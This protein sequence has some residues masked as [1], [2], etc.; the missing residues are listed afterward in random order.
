M[1]RPFSSDGAENKMSSSL[2]GALQQKE[3][4]QLCALM[5]MMSTWKREPVRGWSCWQ[6]LNVQLLHF[7]LHHPLC[8]RPTLRS[9]DMELLLLHWKWDGKW[10]RCGFTW[11]VMLTFHQGI[12]TAA[13]VYTASVQFNF[14]L[15]CPFLFSIQCFPPKNQMTIATCSDRLESSI[16]LN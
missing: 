13:F 11:R 7:T 16:Q 15:K 6:A 3:E 8:P 5:L 2:F 4:E 9:Q 12:G 10:W 14:F 1:V